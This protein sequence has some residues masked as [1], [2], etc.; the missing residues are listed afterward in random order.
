MKKTAVIRVRVDPDLKEET[1]KIF[2]ALGLSTT[3]AITLFYQQVKWHRGLPFELR[4][5]NETTLRT[6]EDTDAGE[7]LVRCRDGEEM[8]NRLG[9]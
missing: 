6:F 8:F 4:I 2:E 3:Q 1:E 5:P 7:K 9:I